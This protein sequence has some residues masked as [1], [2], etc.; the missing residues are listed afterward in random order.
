MCA[1]GMLVLRPADG[2]ETS[3][4]YKVAIENRHRPS[5]LALSRQNLPHL[6]GSSIEAVARGAY[7]LVDAPAP[8]ITLV[9][10]GS[11]ARVCAGQRDM[12]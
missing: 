11:E 12:M 8:A 4:A 1:A 5:V 3:G 9:A 7:V 10:S 2:N 6:T